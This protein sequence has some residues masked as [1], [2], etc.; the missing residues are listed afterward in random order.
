MLTLGQVVAGTLSPVAA[1]YFGLRALLE[2]VA[3]GSRLSLSSFLEALPGSEVK[4]SIAAA[5]GTMLAS[6]AILE[7]VWRVAPALPEALAR[8]KVQRSKREAVP[9]DS[10]PLSAPLLGHEDADDRDLHSGVEPRLEVEDYPSRTMGDAR[11]VV[12]SIQ[13]LKKVTHF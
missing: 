5:A 4:I 1:F 13:G 12:V 10:D 9:G 7:C 3:Q 8:C 2:A 6:I 11:N